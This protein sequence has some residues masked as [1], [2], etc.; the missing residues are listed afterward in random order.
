MSG[1]PMVPKVEILDTGQCW[2]LLST[3]SVGRLAVTVDGHPDLFPVNYKID[4]DTLI[5]RTGDGTKLR[6]IKNDARVA[7]ET[8]A[9][10]PESGVAWSVVIKGSIEATPSTSPALNETERI[11]FP[12]QGVGQDHFVRII[13]ETV[14]G[15]RFTLDT[16]M[17]WQ[18]SLD[19]SIRAG[20]E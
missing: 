18:I 11:L 9:V 16:S 13:P 20:L 6:A 4:E 3:T 10:T 15:R 12:W 1:N 2:K 14:T 17:T 7:F 5:F 19:G 8:D